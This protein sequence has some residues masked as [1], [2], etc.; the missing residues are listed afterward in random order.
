LAHDLLHGPE[1]GR[2]P[3]EAIFWLKRYI[4]GT[5]GGE[6]TRI[7]MTQLGSAYAMPIRGDRDLASARTAWELAAAMGDAV[8]MCFLGAMHEHGLGV[9][10]ATGTAATWYE[11]AA[12][13]GG[14]CPSGAPERAGR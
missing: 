2:D 13:A 1:S 8:A 9:P 10:V 11:R 6:R 4:T 14:T 7:A 12:A 3:E 5:S